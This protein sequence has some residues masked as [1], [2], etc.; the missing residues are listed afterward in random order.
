[1]RHLFDRPPYNSR[2]AL[3]SIAGFSMVI[4][5]DGRRAQAAHCALAVFA[6]ARR[7]L[8]FR[9]LL[10]RISNSRTDWPARDPSRRTVSSRGCAIT[11]ILATPLVC[12]DAA[13]ALEQLRRVEC[14]LLGG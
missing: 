7:N 5:S 4:C 8:L 12:A 1:M 11:G 2:H 3:A 9:I 6:C 14:S 10:S 13:L